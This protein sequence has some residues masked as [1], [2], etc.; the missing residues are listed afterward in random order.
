VTG[1]ATRGRTALCRLA[2]L[3]GDPAFAGPLAQLAAEHPTPEVRR[4]AAA[5]AALARVEGTPAEP[6]GEGEGR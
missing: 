6:N 1:L 3:L 4:A 2:G 5:A